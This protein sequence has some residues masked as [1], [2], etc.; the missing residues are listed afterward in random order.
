MMIREAFDNGCKGAQSASE[1][2]L[3]LGSTS[4]ALV[5]GLVPVA[6]GQDLT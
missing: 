2:N 6:L 1:V 4:V 3:V 5:Q